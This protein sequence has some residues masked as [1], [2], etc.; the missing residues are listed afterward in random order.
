[1]EESM[2]RTIRIAAAAAL[3][4]VGAARAE[5]KTNVIDY[6]QGDTPL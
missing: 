6:T 4:L 3:P 2:E 5:V 1:V